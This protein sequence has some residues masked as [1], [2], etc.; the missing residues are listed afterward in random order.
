MR[1]ETVNG[2]L[3]RISL[4]NQNMRLVLGMIYTAGKECIDVW[5]ED[6]TGLMSRRML[7]VAGIL[8]RQR[9]NPEEVGLMGRNYWQGEEG[10]KVDAALVSF[11]E[12]RRNKRAG[13]RKKIK[14]RN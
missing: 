2:V 10:K 11:I 7:R 13:E 4:G 3:D 1:E 9:I 14:P 5:P 12:T 6:K 8:I